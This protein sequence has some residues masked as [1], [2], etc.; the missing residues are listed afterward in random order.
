M[1]PLDAAA[2]GH[3]EDQNLWLETPLIK[4]NQIS[5]LLGCKVYL[6]LENLQPSQSF[7]YRGISHFAQH[8]RRKY[9]PQVHLIIASGGNAGLAAACASNTLGLRCTVYIPEGVSQGLIESL[10]KEAAEVIIIGKYYQESLR[11]AEEAVSDDVNS[12]MVP[13]YDD[14]IVW[15]GHASMVEEI[16]RQLGS[17]PSA[18]FCSIGGGGLIGGVMLGCKEVGWDDVPIVGLETHGSACFYHSISFNAGKWLDGAAAPPEI[19]LSFDQTYNVTIAHVKEITSKASSL[20]A[21]V[22]APGVVKMAL[23]RQGLVI[24]VKVPDEMSMQA[25][26]LFANDHKF[27]VELACATTLVP[28]YNTSLFSKIQTVAEDR[29]HP[30]AKRPVVF[31]VC[32]GSKISLEEMEQYRKIVKSTS[33]TQWSVCCNGEQWVVPHCTG[34]QPL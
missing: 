33:G 8:C 16:S 30:T 22:P 3:P 7:K 25:S 14:Q 19:S 15:N 34:P 23:N 27:I 28:A 2:T 5:A 9:G 29:F 12:V 26:D 18:I 21:T 13:A 1:L 6:K 32:G 4:S 17:K 24:N 11:R 31:I 10:R 20:G